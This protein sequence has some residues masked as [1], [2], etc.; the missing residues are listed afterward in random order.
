MVADDERAEELSCCL[1]DP[2]GRVFRKLAEDFNKGCI[3]NVIRGQAAQLWEH[4]DS[5]VTHTP[6]IVS[7]EFLEHWEQNSYE[8]HFLAYFGNIDDTFDTLLP[9]SIHWVFLK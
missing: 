5:L 2:F 8:H 1:F 4:F 7:A 9:Y 3:L 6:H